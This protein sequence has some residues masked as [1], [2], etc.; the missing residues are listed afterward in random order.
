MKSTAMIRR[1]EDTLKVQ[2]Q[3]LAL[4]PELEKGKVFVCTIEPFREKRSLTANNYSWALQNEIAKVLNRRVDDIHAEMVLQYGVLENYS[5]QK[6]ALESAQRM[7]DYF[8]ILGESEA[9]GKM[10]VHI[11]AG[12]GTAKYNLKEMWHF[13]QGVIAEAQD[14]GIETKTPEELAKLEGLK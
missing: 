12:I 6:E 4:K 3:L 5:V 14:L 10:F 9:N 1:L 2:A 8:K 13:I 11:R 7:F